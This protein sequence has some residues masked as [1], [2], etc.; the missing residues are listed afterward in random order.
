MRCECRR[1]PEE[2][3][4]ADRP[5]TP[6]GAWKHPTLALSLRLLPP[7]ELSNCG[8]IC[9]GLSAPSPFFPAPSHLLIASG[10]DVGWSGVGEE[11][12]IS[13]MSMRLEKPKMF[14]LAILLCYHSE[15]IQWFLI[16]SNLG[17]L[18]ETAFFPNCLK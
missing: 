9:F 10:V 3:Q 15:N 14:V 4:N 13:E 2:P 18:E 12:Q 11:E 6:S 1:G 7:C 8:Q 5:E 17:Y 16:T